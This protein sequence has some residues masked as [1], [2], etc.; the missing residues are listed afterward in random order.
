[1]LYDI[2]G[3]ICGTVVHMLCLQGGISL[4][5]KEPDWGIKS[6]LA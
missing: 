3:E 4:E 2:K 5:A 6:T 1:M